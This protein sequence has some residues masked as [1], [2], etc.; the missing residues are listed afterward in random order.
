MNTSPT[1]PPRPPEHPRY[2]GTC[3]DCRETQEGPGYLGEFVHCYA[4]LNRAARAELEAL[5]QRA[6]DLAELDRIV[7]VYVMVPPQIRGE[8]Y[9]DILDWLEKHP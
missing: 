8:A 7:R 9:R 2:I 5:R 6:A 4:C 3:M 1:P